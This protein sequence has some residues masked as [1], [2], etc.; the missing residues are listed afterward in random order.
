MTNEIVE[1]IKEDILS[2]APF[3]D[4]IEAIGIFGSVLR[5]DFSKYSDIDVLVVMADGRYSDEMDRFWRRKI[6]DVLYGYH[7]QRNVFIYEIND[8][9]RISNWYVFELASDCLLIYDRGKV[10]RI[11]GKIVDKALNEWCLKREKYKRHYCWG[12][13]RPAKPGE[14]LVFSLTEEDLKEIGL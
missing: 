1:R 13:A 7:R 4:E 6:K 8:L 12:L 2:L 14:K 5:D 11:F 9:I 3:P 10:K